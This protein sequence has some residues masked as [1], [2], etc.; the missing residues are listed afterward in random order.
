MT[1]EYR[2]VAIWLMRG[3]PQAPRYSF[4]FFSSEIFSPLNEMAQS[5]FAWVDCW[6]RERALEGPMAASMRPSASRWCG[7]ENLGVQPA[8]PCGHRLGLWRSGKSGS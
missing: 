4:S 2:H 8:E 7:P 1:H 6:L 5:Y 3:A